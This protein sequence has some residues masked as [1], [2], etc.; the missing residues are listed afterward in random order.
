M[1]QARACA[2]ARSGHDLAA[3]SDAV[4]LISGEVVREPEI[5]EC[6]SGSS[7]LLAPD[8]SRRHLD[9]RRGRKEDLAR[10]VH[11]HRVVATCP[12]IGPAC[13]ELPNTS[14]NGRNAYGR[15]LVEVGGRFGR[16]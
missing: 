7:Q 14:A 10:L 8:S 11:H 16:E 9:Q 4:E 2:N 13:V 12:D 3:D 15:E 5:L 6:I 1:G